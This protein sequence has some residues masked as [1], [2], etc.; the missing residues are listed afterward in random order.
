VRPSQ[1]IYVTGVR[2][3][4][5]CSSHRAYMSQACVLDRR[6]ALIGYVSHRVLDF[7]KKDLG[8][9]EKFPTPTVKNGDA[10]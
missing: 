8:F 9:W 10:D 2:L 4:Q 5:V 3:R 1:G 7:E 6:A